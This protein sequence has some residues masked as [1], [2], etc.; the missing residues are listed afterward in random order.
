MLAWAAV[1]TRERWGIWVS[2]ARA[3]KRAPA[4]RAKADGESG[5]SIEPPGVDGERVPRREVGEN[6][7]LVSP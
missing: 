2:T 5:A 1:N 7:P 3:T 4:P 6:W